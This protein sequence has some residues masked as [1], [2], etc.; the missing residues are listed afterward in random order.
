M[1]RD[2]CIANRE[3][4]MSELQ[5]YADELFVLHQALAENDADKLQEIFSLARAVRSGWTQQ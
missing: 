4:L 1:W 5:R 2:I 3:A